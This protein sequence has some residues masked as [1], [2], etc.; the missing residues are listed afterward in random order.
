[1][2]SL[3]LCTHHTLG[4]YH[5]IKF[6]INLPDTDSNEV[7]VVDSESSSSLGSH[8]HGVLSEFPVVR[9]QSPTP[10]DR[11]ETSVGMSEHSLFIERSNEWAIKSR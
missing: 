1:M 3:Q 4:R 6:K 11:A 9:D 5:M 7:S 2:G 10:L 8:P